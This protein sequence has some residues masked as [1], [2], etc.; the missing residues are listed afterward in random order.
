MPWF[1]TRYVQSLEQEISRLRTENSRLVEHS[2][3]LVERLLRKG[4]VASVEL[5]PEPTKEAIDKM[6]QSH[7]IFEDME[8]PKESDLT[9]NRKEQYDEFVS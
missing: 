8:E 1:K 7:N 9:D 3:R 5:P 4:G 2:E 6:L